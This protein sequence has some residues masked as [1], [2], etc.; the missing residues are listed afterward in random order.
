M[1]KGERE[2]AEQEQQERKKAAKLRYAENNP[3]KRRHSLVVSN[4]KK[5]AKRQLVREGIGLSEE[6]VKMRMAD[7]AGAEEE[8]VVVM[9]GEEGIGKRGDSRGSPMRGGEQQENGNDMVSVNAAQSTTSASAPPATAE[10]RSA[11]LTDPQF[12]VDNEVKEW[13][14]HLERQPPAD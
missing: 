8:A 6:N 7:L 2:K 5:K 4:R 1:A 14:P 9:V 10:G 11:I 12:V 3:E 13:Y